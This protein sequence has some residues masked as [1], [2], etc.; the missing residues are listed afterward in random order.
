M[1]HVKAHADQITHKKFS[2]SLFLYITFLRLLLYRGRSPANEYDL[3]R[4]V[5]LFFFLSSS[6][7]QDKKSFI[8]SFF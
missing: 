1:N 6:A 2:L 3:R 7:Q 4:T 5:L 8:S